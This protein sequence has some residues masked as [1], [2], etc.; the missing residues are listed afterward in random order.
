[1]GEG[2]LQQLQGGLH[3]YL[4]ERQPKLSKEICK[5]TY[6][7]YLVISVYIGMKSNFNGN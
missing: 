2:L 6:E 4:L 5:A 3:K 1:M 7:V